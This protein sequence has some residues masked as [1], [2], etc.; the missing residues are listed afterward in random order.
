MSYRANMRHVCHVIVVLVLAGMMGADRPAPIVTVTKAD[1]TTVR[2][3]VTVSE[4][5]SI[6]VTPPAPRPVVARPGRPVAAPAEPAAPVVVPWSEIK[7]VSN[8]LTQ[9]NAF[10]QW[11]LTHHDLLCPTCHGERTVLCPTCKGTTHDPASGKDCP[12]CHGELLVDCKDPRCDNGQVPCPNHCLQLTEGKWVTREDGLKWRSFPIGNAVASFSEHHLG[13]VITIDRKA[14]TAND[15]GVCPVC[16]G[17][18]KADCPLCHGVGK[19]PC[20]TC[21]NRKDAP[22][23][24]AHCDHGRV[25]CADCDGTGVKKGAAAAATS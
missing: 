12:T 2:G 17:T 3:T 20:A 14:G 13:H 7:S 15:T 25:K 10:S 23:C 1:G 9:A 16:N 8:G 18:T 6:I 5:D 24:P 22:A 19:V 21:V 11:K 4:P